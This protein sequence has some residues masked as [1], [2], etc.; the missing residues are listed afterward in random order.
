MSDKKQIKTTP[1]QKVSTNLPANL[2]KDIAEILN[3]LP[4]EK[5]EKAFAIICSEY[6]QGP[7]PSPAAI[8]RYNA[9]IPNGADR[10]MKMAE[11]QSAHRKE[12]EK[13]VITSQQKQSERGQIFGL[14]IGLL[15]IIIGAFLIY[16]GH[17]WAGGIIGGTTVV[18]LVSVFVIGKQFQQR[19]LKPKQINKPS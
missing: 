16:C 9:I 15:G 19:S 10:I 1:A 12:I 4:E 6:H 3:S 13:T 11:E 7:I 5:R 14:I 17:D 18:S 2:D 8:E